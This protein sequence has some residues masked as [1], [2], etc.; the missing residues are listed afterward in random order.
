LPV[1]VRNFAPVLGNNHPKW[2]HLDYL[3]ETIRKNEE[4]LYEKISAEEFDEKFDAGED[5]LEYCDTKSIRKP[6]FEKK[7]VF[8]E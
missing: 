7:L 8:G 1:L 2:K 5:V 6:G 4:R 3:C